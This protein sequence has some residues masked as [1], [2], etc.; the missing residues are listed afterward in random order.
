MGQ[1]W[2]IDV[3]AD[4]RDFAERNG[5][6]LLANQLEVTASVARTEIETHLN[7]VGPVASLAKSQHVPP[8]EDI[9]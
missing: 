5:L 1:K 9:G 8:L 2:I 3:I 6:P 4:L 7:G